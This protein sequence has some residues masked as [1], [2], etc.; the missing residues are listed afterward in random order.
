VEQA[1]RE[2]GAHAEHVVAL[3][4]ITHHLH[5]LALERVGAEDGARVVMAWY[6]SRRTSGRSLKSWRSTEKRK[7]VKEK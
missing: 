5:V 2:D 1:R 7:L 4:Q 3:A 6:G